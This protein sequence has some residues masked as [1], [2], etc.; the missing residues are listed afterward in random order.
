[1]PR[2]AVFLLAIGLVGY[3][4]LLARYGA[5]Y[6]A[7]SDS[8]GYFNSARLLREGRVADTPRV[9]AGL[10]HTEFGRMAFQPLGF[11][12]DTAAPR[13]IPTYPTG[14]PLHLLLASWLVGWAHAA[15]VVNIFAAL[16]TGVLL[17]WMARR[18]QLPPAWAALAVALLWLCPLTLFA[19][20][21]PMSDL[22][23]MFWSLAALWFALRSAEARRW[24][25]WAGVATSLAVLVRPTSV[26]LLLPLALAF[27]RDFRR[28]LLLGVGGLPG[29]LFFCYY[30]W[31]AYGS[32]LAS[33]Y[34]DIWNAFGPVNLGPNLLHFARWIPALLTPLVALVLVAPFLRAGRQRA[35]AVLGLWSL[36]QIGFYAFYYHSGETWWYLRFI[37]PVFPALILTTLVVLRHGWLRLAS[38]LWARITLAVL[39]VLALGWEITLNRRLAVLTMAAGEVNYLHIAGWAGGQLPP[40]SAVFCMQVSGALHFYTPL[41]LIRW[42]EVIPAEMPRLFAVLQAEKRPVYA[43]LFDFERT[44][45]FNRL[46]GRWT[47]IN[48]VGPA[49]CWKLETGPATP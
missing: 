33:G 47:Q 34:G 35:L 49:T 19:A 22:L 36:L 2:A 28:Y 31:R 25:F 10:S 45:A 11:A 38:A 4:L 3:A 42:D 8:S 24:A 1:L 40:D 18:L 29:A 17:W 20:L 32:P 44:E 27:G 46:G 43:I 14:L 48:T 7:G 13:L 16:G 5:S 26:L 9:P 39:V 30:N 37:L 21:Q 41:M 12:A 15:I 6:A 23:A